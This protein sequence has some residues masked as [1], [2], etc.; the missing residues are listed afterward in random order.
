MLLRRRDYDGAV[1]STTAMLEKEPR[2]Q[3]AWYLK[4]RALTE[5]VYVDDTDVEEA[6]LAE[7][8]M[9]E[10]AMASV[11]RPGTSFV[12][13]TS[14]GTGSGRPLTGFARPSTTSRGTSSG[15]RPMTSRPIA[16]SAGRYVRLNTAAFL[17]EPDGPFIPV[18]SLDL[19]RYAKRQALAKVLF[20]Y[21][22]YVDG[23]PLKAL[24]LA[25]AAHERA[26]FGDWWW[27][28]QIG[29]C[30][31][32]LGLL[33]D[34]QKFHL[35]G[36]VTQ[37]MVETYLHLGKIFFR[38]DQ[39]A[40][41]LETYAKGLE[42]HPNDT[43]L[44]VGLARV[45]DALGQTEDAVTTYKAVLDA[46]PSNIEAAASLGSY[47]FY[48]DAPEIALR[49]YRRLLQMGVYSTAVWNNVG[50]CCFY[51][52][53]FDMALSCFERALA[54][55]DDTDTAQVWYNI[56]H[57]AVAAGD[58][59]LAH[60]AC[61]LATAADPNHAPA[62]NN[63]GVLELLLGNPSLARSEFTTAAQSAPWLHGPQYNSALLA[64][65]LGEFE[66]AHKYAKEATVLDP[67]HAPSSIL[68]SELSKT[69]NS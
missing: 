3:A 4:A 63:L 32:L 13:R 57:V 60:Q 43:S 37:S 44:L 27:K 9:D 5:K 65:K 34:A 52:Q 61:K 23:N 67:S 33:R 56:S 7:A 18:A 54:L 25:T 41:A 53:Q 69:L 45:H 24:E 26:K 8:L 39:P 12:P 62:A 36:L 30:Y 51:S 14:G 49:F 35:S 46:D 20:G 64:Y 1:A 48:A 68:L 66:S 15:G 10:H 2:D 28:V 29:K 50:L 17:A 11:P 31:Y 21:I 59:A 19:R 55:A 6:G 58:I 42:R 38:L 16:S 40:K 47:Y 22:L